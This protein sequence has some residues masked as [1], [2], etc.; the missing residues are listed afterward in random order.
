[1][2]LKHGPLMFLKLG[3]VPLVVVSSA[4]TA[5]ELFKSHDLTISNRPVTYT[6]RKLSYGCSDMAFAPY[7]EYWRQVRK[8]CTLELFSLKRAQ[9]YRAVREEEAALLLGSIG[10]N[11]SSSSVIINM[12]ESVLALVNDIHIFV[13]GTDTSSTAQ[14]ELR[15]A[16]GKKERVEESDLNGLDY[17]KMIIKET[18][19]MHPPVP[20][21]LPREA[22]EEF[23]LE[24]YTI[25]AKAQIFVNATAIGLD[26]KWRRGCP[27]INFAT[28]IVELT[29]ANL[30]HRFDWELPP[31]IGI[32]DLDM[33][34]AIGVTTQKRIPLCLIATAKA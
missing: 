11:S 33:K 32:V 29:L 34:E 24:G 31:G 2:S 20:L 17:L 28:P 15:K 16:I 14:E 19:R 9:S 7:R 18:F 8:L 10:L 5:Q 25:P 23:T 26:P 3:S 4:D 27:D 6:Q 13:A 22:T 12:S 21:L 1:M 30:L